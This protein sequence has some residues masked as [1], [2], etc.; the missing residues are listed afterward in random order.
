MAAG[1]AWRLFPVAEGS[2]S[3]WHLV[4]GIAV[5]PECG[6]EQRETRAVVTMEPAVVAAVAL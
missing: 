3:I 2:G 1:L 6:M 5:V 4:L